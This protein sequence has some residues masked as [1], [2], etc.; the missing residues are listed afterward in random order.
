V[1]DGAAGVTITGGTQPYFIQWTLLG[2]IVGTGPALVDR[3]AG[4]Y[5]AEVTDAN[6]CSASL[7]VPISDVDG[8]ELT[9]VD[10]VTTCPNTCD[11]S[12]QL[13]YTCSA[14]PCTVTWYDAGGAEIA[15]AVEQ[16]DGL[17]PGDYF[18]QVVN[19]SGCLTVDTATVLVPDPILANLGTT[20]V[21]CF[22]NCDGTAT[23]APTGG[24][25]PYV[26]AWSPE[27]GGGQGTAVATGLC[28]G[29]YAVLITDAN[30]CSIEQDALILG[31][32]LLTVDAAVNNASCSGVCDGVISLS[33]QGGTA[34]Y[35]FLWTPPPPNG[36]TGAIA[37]QLC[38]GPWQVLVS[39]ANGCDTLLT[40]VVTEPA[41]LEAA[42]STVDNICNGDCLGTAE[43]VVQGGTAPYVVTW[44]DAGGTV[45]APDQ[46]AIDQLCAGTYTVSVVD[47]NGCTRDLTFIIGQGPPIVPGLFVT[48]ETCAGPCNGT[49]ISTPDGGQGPYQFLWQPEPAAGQGTAIASGLCEGAYTVTITDQAG[50][51]TTAAVVIAPY[52]PVDPGAVIADAGCP[53]SCDGSVLLDPTGGIGSLSFLWS[54]VPANGQGASSATGLC[55]GE[56]TLTVTDAALCASTFTYTIGAPPAWIVVVD[57][58]VPA[59]CTNS[60][61]GAISVT[62]GGATSPLTFQWSGPVGYQSV[63]EDISGLAP[64]DHT[65]TVTDAN[66]C[67]TTVVVNVPVI[68]PLLADAGPDR[69]VCAGVDVVLEGFSNVP[70]VSFQWTDDQGQVLGELSTISLG[71]LPIGPNTITLTVTDGVCTVTDQVVIDVLELPLAQAGDDRSIFLGGTTTIGGSPS[72]PPGSVFSWVADTTLSAVD[73]PNP[74]ASPAVN[75]WYTLTVV[76]PNGCQDTDS[77]LVRVLPELVIPSGFSPNGDGWNDAWIIDL[78]DLFPECEVEIYNR[79]GEMLFRSVGYRTP[80]DGRYNGGPVPVGTYYYIVKL[81]D[82]EY[83]DAYT[84]PLTVIR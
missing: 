26:Y 5:V 29:T 15:Q 28:V 42:L 43:V 58:V 82:P 59:T 51:D 35:T 18:V 45:I 24:L 14:P 69:R 72:G 70:G 36:A 63:L 33:P 71:D 2:A 57:A 31:P 80:W 77:V 27:P 13:S 65:L 17:C 49:A 12:V 78:I 48:G 40:F 10:G 7:V 79:W 32:S 68:N 4:I 16:V 39:D 62:T 74:V 21:S 50:C 3:C 61:D 81:N 83:P 55:G 11:G 76:A 25:A 53:G 22:G 56:I 60:A 64:G 38:P 19:G 41:P 44:R 47:D 1:C 54:P 75:T 20:P 8:E 66:G 67:D 37:E 52:V 84:G 9:T 46:T 73:V 30:G 34:P 6:G 23:V